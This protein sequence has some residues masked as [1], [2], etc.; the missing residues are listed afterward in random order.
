MFGKVRS[1]DRVHETLYDLEIEIDAYG[2]SIE[3]LRHLKRLQVRTD[4][5][6]RSQI[7]GLRGQRTPWAEIAAALDM[8]EKEVEERYGY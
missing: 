3:Q 6:L 4:S 2:G 5:V 8:P 1:F 7:V